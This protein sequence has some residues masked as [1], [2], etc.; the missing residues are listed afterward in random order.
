MSLLVVMDHPAHLH[1]ESD[2]T[3]TFIEAMKRRA[4]VWICRPTQL[5]LDG[6]Q[7][8]ATAAEVTTADRNARPALAWGAEQRKPLGEFGAVFMRKDPPFDLDYYFATLLLERARGR[9][10]LVND[11]RGLREANE[12]LYIFHF[13]QLIAPT[14]VTR[15]LER[16]RAF[17]QEH[18]GEM[19]VKPLDQCGGAGV[20]HV[21]AD[22]RNTNAILETV[23]DCGKKL[24]M[25]QKYLPAARQ[26]DK[27]ILLLD[28]E[29]LGAVLR[30]PRADE[31]RGN[32]HVGGKAEKATLTPRDLEICKQVGA[33]CKADGLYFVGL[34]VIGDWLTE[35][36]VTSPTGVQEIDRLDGARLEDRVADWLTARMM[37]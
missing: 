34:D 28:G 23:S 26:G 22:D 10:F 17:L 6:D 12:K 24:V 37:R 35:V 9:T 19:V 16:L 3:L 29:P 25:A 31:T 14:C 1:P 2:T 11:P 27:R 30:V 4:P 33:R 20:F 18:G 8:F 5:E 13:P 36:N 15:S 32:L 21:R 7:V